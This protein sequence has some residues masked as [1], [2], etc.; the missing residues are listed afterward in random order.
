MSAPDD[1]FAFLRAEIDA[2]RGET[3]GSGY[4]GTVVVCDTP[5]AGKVVVKQPGGG[6]LAGF[7][8]WMIRRELRAYLRLDGLPG[9]PVCHGLMDGGDLVI[10]FEPGDSYKEVQHALADRDTFFDRLLTL[11][12]AMHAAGVAHGDLKRKYNLIVADGERPVIIDFGT[13]VRNKQKSGPFGRWLFGV[14]ARADVNAWIKLK[15]G[16]NY[17]GMSDTDRAIFKPSRTER[18]LR[19]VRRFWRTLTMRQTRKKWRRRQQ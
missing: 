18:V 12:R 8:R 16:A 13:A 3:L 14:V 2:G 9:I 6:V 15:Y 1:L 17:D 10:S 11:I 4:Q 5:M 19:V 7:R